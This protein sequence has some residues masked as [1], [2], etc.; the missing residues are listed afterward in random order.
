MTAAATSAGSSTPFDL[1]RFSEEL[2]QAYDP[3]N[4]HERMLVSQIAQSRERLERAY[5]LE[6]TYCRDRD[7]AEI[8][9]TKLDE[10]KVVMRYLTDSER[11]WR[12]AVLTLEKAQRRRKREAA[13]VATPVRTPSISRPAAQS[14]QRETAARSEPAVASPAAVVAMPSPQRE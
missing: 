8:V 14:M 11:A 4:A 13:K 2:A 12:H 3:Q 6:R 1:A 9:R 7:L 5:E 10:F